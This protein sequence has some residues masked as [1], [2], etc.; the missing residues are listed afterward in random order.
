MT[1]VLTPFGDPGPA[2]WNG[3]RD[4]IAVRSRT[5]VSGKRRPLEDLPRRIRLGVRRADEPAGGDDAPLRRSFAVARPKYTP[6][7][8]ASF[9]RSTSDRPVLPCWPAADAYWRPSES[10]RWASRTASS[11]FLRLSISGL[12]QEKFDHR[13]DDVDVK[14]LARND[15]QPGA[16]A[17][18]WNR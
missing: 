12:G 2:A 5:E 7:G 3:G 4:G 11:S 6:R 13:H 9:K 14:V 8:A 1:D 15:G 18:C 16:E 17:R 10:Q